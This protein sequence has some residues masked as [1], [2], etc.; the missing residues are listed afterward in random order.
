V[1]T[2][3]SKLPNLFTN[4]EIS[5]LDF[6]SR[7]LARARR[8][9]VPLL[10]RL[11]FVAI[12]AANLDEFY[13]V[14]VSALLGAASGRVPV[15]EASG[16]G[17]RP[18][19]VVKEIGQRAKTMSLE[20][21]RTL[22][23]GI[24][25]DL[26]GHRVRLLDPQKLS[27][28]QREKIGAF[29]RREVHPCLTPVAVD[30]AHPFPQLRNRSL[31]LAVRLE[32]KPKMRLGFTEPDTT[33][34]LALVQVPSVLPRFVPIEL[35]GTAY[36]FVPLEQIIA[37]HASELFPGHR[38][39]ES[40][41]FRVTRASDLEIVE[42][43]VENLLT[44]IQD[45]L[46][47]RDRRD[48]VRLEILT[49][50]SDDLS[51]GLRDMLGIDTAHVHQ[52]PGL[53]AA[54]DMM[55]LYR[56]IDLPELKDEPF[57][58]VPSSALR[59]HRNLFQRLSEG[60][61]LL[62]HP[63]ESFAH[64]VDFIESAAEDPDVVAIKLT[65]YRTSG[66][67]P[68]VRALARAADRGKQV[69]A[70]VELKARFDE[71][72]NIAWARSLEENGVHVVYGLIGLKVHSKLLL[73]IR[74]EGSELKRYLHLSTG[75]YNPITARIYTDLSL[76]TAREDMTADAMLLFNVL[77]G[78]GEL[79]PMQ[80]L[81]V[82]P[83][84]LR[85]H[86]VQSI[87]REIDHA[88]A[89]RPARII[90]KLNALVDPSVIR[91]LYRASQAGVQ[92]DLMVRG[93]CCL[94]AG[95][96]GVSENIRVRAII[97]RFLE[98]ARIYYWANG[99]NE[100]IELASADWMPRNLN[101]RVEVVFPILDPQIKRRIKDE[102]LQTELSDNVSSWTL[103]SEGNYAPVQVPEDQSAVRAQAVFM[104][105]AKDR[106]VPTRT[107]MRREMAAR[108]SSNT[109]SSGTSPPAVS[110]AARIAE[111]QSWRRRSGP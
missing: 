45:E 83:F 56:K 94:R 23:E 15:Q 76:L 26:E 61:V 87:A 73:V 91:A 67:S 51:D 52:Y 99:G 16:D 12:A 57:T 69:T 107:A 80:R 5:W 89:G 71:A 78:Y 85:Q 68:I 10:E 102:I 19:D 81:I 104:S 70:V 92:I 60:D 32:A 29:Y 40:C 47:R 79:P 43:E 109:A 30:P 49:G 3:D 58:P 65:L 62:H 66:D 38:I 111:I 13:M 42:E 41:S 17:Q 54:G 110:P 98:H 34:L 101:R 35:E 33:T 6:N 75:N 55:D 36:A 74:R 108:A 103:D 18:S 44:T 97:D 25:P 1:T 48:P 14:R 39:I 72:A 2:N 11:K 9:D 50:A 77:T 96:P 82:A 46:R 106:G 7:V 53:L 86:L 21:A 88:N 95:V 100:E 64:V 22:T 105:L 20:I 37:A 59:Y 31:N 27:D 24:L 90:A 93:I 8:R 63:Y 4:R 84:N 28:D